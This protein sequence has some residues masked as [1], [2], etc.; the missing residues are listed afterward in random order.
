[1]DAE[2]A[3][4]YGMVDDILGEPVIEEDSEDGSGKKS[5]PKSDE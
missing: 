5:S 3:K 1:M 4:E 2:A